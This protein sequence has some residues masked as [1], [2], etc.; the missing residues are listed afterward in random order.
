[1]CQILVVICTQMCSYPDYTLI[2]PHI[3][4]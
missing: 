1:M 2:K 3:P 4:S